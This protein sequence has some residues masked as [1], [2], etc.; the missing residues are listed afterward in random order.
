MKNALFVAVLAVSS[1]AFA[2]EPAKAAAPAAKAAAPA[3]AP[4]APA[5]PAAAP[6]ATAATDCDMH[7]AQAAMMKDV[8]ASKAKVQMIKLDRGTTSI[9][10]ADAK[11]APAVEKSMTA[12][13]SSMKTAME[14]KAKLCDACQGA[15]AAMKAGKAMGG[16]GHAGMV[17]TNTMLSSDDGMVKKMHEEMDAKLAAAAPAKK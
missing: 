10:T 13:E 15:M 5:A 6:A 8:M 1:L 16:M 2:A 14:G 3:V 11:S 4:A 17:W 7:K 12:M 9:I